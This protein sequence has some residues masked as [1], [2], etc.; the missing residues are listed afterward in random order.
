MTTI[1]KH[2]AHQF[3]IRILNWFKSHGRHDL[4]WQKNSNAYRVYLS[5]IML[6]QTQVITVIGYYERFLKAFPTIESLAAASNDEVLA[7]WSGLGYYARA[8]NL[9]TTAQIICNEFD[10][11][12]PDS[13]EAMQNLPGIGK[14]TAAAVLTFALG[15]SHAILDAN[16]KRV[17]SRHYE[18]EGWS[19]AAATLKQLWLISK[20]LTPAINT[21]EYNQAMMDMGATICTRSKPKCTKCCLIGSCLA[22]KNDSWS[23][24]PKPKPKKKKPFKEAYLVLFKYKETALLEKRA[25]TGIWGGL[26]SLPEFNSQKSA[27]DWLQNASNHFELKRVS[28]YKKELLHRFSHYDFMIHL[29]VYKAKHLNNQVRENN[30]TMASHDMLTKVGLP[31][32]IK[33]LL[34]KYN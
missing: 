3:S 26:W 18:I 24:Y 5:E 6:Q 8:R 20:T 1:S 21:P 12:F 29:V 4:P 16:V 17:L 33:T 19:G 9:H 30:Y 15:Q 13:L 14:S 31:A 28:L 22:Y 7:L 27:Y 32:P 25:E 23:K 2:Q 11:R 10:G 34:K